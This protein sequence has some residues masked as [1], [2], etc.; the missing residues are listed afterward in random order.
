MSLT[1]EVTCYVPSCWMVHAQQDRILQVTFALLVHA[2]SGA[3]FPQEVMA[4]HARC[5][6][7]AWQRGSSPTCKTKGMLVLCDKSL[8][9]TQDMSSTFPSSSSS[10]SNVPGLGS[11]P[12]ISYPELRAKLLSNLM[13][14]FSRSKG[15]TS[16]LLPF[17]PSSLPPNFRN[18]LPAARAAW[19]PQPSCKQAACP[20]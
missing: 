20:G 18:A 14:K 8:P 7:L 2:W 3:G 19:A 11:G 1:D 4:I 15:S 16:A 13:P 12:G 6:H 10:P 17:Q 9:H 5:T